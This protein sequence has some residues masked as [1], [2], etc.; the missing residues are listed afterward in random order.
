MDIPRHTDAL[1]DRRMVWNQ[2]MVVAGL[3]PAL[4]TR[5]MLS[6]NCAA[7]LRRMTGEQIACFPVYCSSQLGIST[8]FIII[9]PDTSLHHPCHIVTSLLHVLLRWKSPGSQKPFETFVCSF[10]L[11][12]HIHHRCLLLAG[13]SRQMRLYYK[14]SA[15]L[16]PKYHLETESNDDH[17]STI[18]W[19]SNK[20]SHIS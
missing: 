5:G 18:R 12:S 1:M 6:A 10:F 19:Q 8:S 15:K 17:I 14:L 11:D 20:C 4:T 9:L 3:S 7:R 16:G 13:L 2:Y